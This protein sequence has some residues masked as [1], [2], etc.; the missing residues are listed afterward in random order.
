MPTLNKKADA[1]YYI[2]YG[3]PETDLVGTYKH[4]SEQALDFLESKGV[5]RAIYGR[6]VKFPQYLLDELRR[7]GLVKS[8]GNGFD[9]TPLPSCSTYYPEPQNDAFSLMLDEYE[10]GWRLM[11]ECP[12]IPASWIADYGYNQIRQRLSTEWLCVAGHKIPARQLL[13]G[14]KV[15]RVEV[16]PQLGDIPIEFSQK[17]PFNI[18]LWRGAAQGPLDTRCTLFDGASGI[19]LKRLRRDE[20]GHSTRPSQDYFVLLN[21]S[22]IQVVTR[23]LWPAPEELNAVLLGKKGTWEA[24][25]FSLPQP[26]P[27]VVCDW[28]D[29]IG[30]PLQ[31]NKWR[32]EIASPPP[33]CISA[34]GASVFH[35][36]QR[37][38]VRAY[39][40]VPDV[41]TE[42]RRK[43]LVVTLDTPTKSGSDIATPLCESHLDIAFEYEPGQE[44]IYRLHSPVPHQVP[45]LRFQT[46]S[47]NKTFGELIE[48]VRPLEVELFEGKEEDEF[49]PFESKGCW[50]GVS[51]QIIPHTIEIEASQSVGFTLSCSAPVLISWRSGQRSDQRFLKNVPPS[52]TCEALNADM[53]HAVKTAGEIAVSFDAGAFGLLNFHLSP[54]EDHAAPN[55]TNLL[56]EDHLLVRERLTW[57]NS[58]LLTPGLGRHLEVP[59]DNSSCRLL[60]SLTSLE[61]WPQLSHVVSQRRIQASFW[62]H[63]KQALNVF[64][65]HL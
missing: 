48:A 43:S 58:A 25:A 63:L 59:L 41:R 28:L 6:K 11:V 3:I 22:K 15:Q 33:L 38:A 56:N 44:G 57:I 23:C 20:Q 13:P 39:C 35:T 31:E 64:S 21:P 47:S 54:K 61:T 45:A 40:S 52:S 49:E 9:E 62:P 30:H 2:R 12:Q 7:L 10:E 1:S 19:R 14:S 16:S 50:R 34:E 51:E 32:Y 42:A 53:K 17:W 18:H 60:Q 4:V 29:S 24:W 37:I 5:S 65:Q 27:I 46:V 8:D 36:G 26:V 55:K